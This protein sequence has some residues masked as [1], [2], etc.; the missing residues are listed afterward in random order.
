MME[1][2]AGKYYIHNHS[3]RRYKILGFVSKIKF[4]I[5]GWL[6]NEEKLVIYEHETDLSDSYARFESDFRSS[7]HHDTSTTSN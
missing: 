3:G 2:L 6:R 1:L 4:P 5:L 7:F